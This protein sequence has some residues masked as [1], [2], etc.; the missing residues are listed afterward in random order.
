MTELSHLCGMEAEQALLGAFFMKPLLVTELASIIEPK[1]FSEPLHQRI[2]ETMVRLVGEGTALTPITL[3]SHFA[4]EEK[5]NDFTVPQYFGRLAAAAS[6]LNAAPYA[7]LVRELFVRRKLHKAGIR[8]QQLAGDMERTPAQAAADAVMEFDG[9]VGAAHLSRMTVH[10]VSDAAAELIGDL[11]RE[12]G[13]PPV[14]TG[15]IDLDNAIGGFTRG[16][17]H[18]LAGRPSIG[19]TAL[20]GAFFLNAARRGYGTMFFSLEMQSQCLPACSPT[21]SSTR[22]HRFHTGTSCATGRIRSDGG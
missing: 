11:D 9:I 4:V 5:I 6:T 20:A 12:E 3:G 16:D 1:H 19:K 10:H 14:P 2:H 22:K 21:L 17:Y 13:E 7:R 15:L 8:A 18:I